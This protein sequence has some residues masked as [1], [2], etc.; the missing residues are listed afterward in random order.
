M[1]DIEREPSLRW[2]LKR[3][4]ADLHQEV[5]DALPLL[6]PELT[7]AVYRRVLERF[8]GFYA[9]HEAQLPALGAALPFPLRQRTALLEA[10]LRALGAT[11]D[12]LEAVPR[13]LPP[14]LKRVEQLAGWLYVFEGAA[15]GGRVVSRALHRNLSLTPD[16]GMA[17]FT[18]DAEGVG[19][20]WTTVSGWLETLPA[21]GADPDLVVAAACDTFARLGAWMGAVHGD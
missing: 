7:I 9:P 15:L 16:R 18:G 20:R 21:A 14:T 19:E 10:D 2:E 12:E 13:C 5:E 8:L 3:A 4:T 1:R 17:F 11:G 6:R